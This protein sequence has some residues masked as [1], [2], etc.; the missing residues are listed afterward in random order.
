METAEQI[1]RKLG[2]LVPRGFSE[3][4]ASSI[5]A[6]LDELAADD[7]PNGQRRTWGWGLAAAAVVL[8]VSLAGL[9]NRQAG[10]TADAVVAV[11]NDEPELVEGLES[12]DDPE[13]VAELEGVVSVEA[14]DGM[15]TDSDGSLHRAWHVRVV[16]EERFHDSETGQEVRVVAPRDELV[17]M[18]VTAF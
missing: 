17:L 13:L 5:E 18:P 12:G 10:A 8:A 2:D 14:D 6:M 1:E 15:L 3:S 16:S 11:P 7:E 9:A 4:G